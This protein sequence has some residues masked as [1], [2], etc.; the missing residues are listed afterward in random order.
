MNKVSPQIYNSQYS[1]VF[2]RLDVLKKLNPNHPEINSF[3]RSSLNALTK[4]TLERNPIHWATAEDL[5]FANMIITGE[6]GIE[7][8]IRESLKSLIDDQN[9][10]LTAQNLHITQ[11]MPTMLR[12]LNKVAKAY[13]ARG[14]LTNVRGQYIDIVTKVNSFVAVP[15]NVTSLKDRSINLLGLMTAL[16]H[17]MATL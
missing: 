15:N 9:T 4:P 11:T 12:N 8:Q 7:P 13:E 2:N 3:E 10:L 14:I 17:N 1:A 16:T 5:N 6:N